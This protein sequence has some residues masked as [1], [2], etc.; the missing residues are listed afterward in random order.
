MIPTDQELIGALL[1]ALE[2]LYVEHILALGQ[3]RRAR[4]AGFHDSA[5]KL[6]LEVVAQTAR[7]VFRKRYAQAVQNQQELR[8][9]LEALPTSYSIQ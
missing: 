9:F 3:L 8:A 2:N 1:L 6:G 5:D 7:E 4:F